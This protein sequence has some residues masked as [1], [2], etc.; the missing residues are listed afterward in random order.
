MKLDLSVHC[1]ALYA[2]GQVQPAEVIAD[3]YDRIEARPDKPHLD[4]PGA[5]RGGARTSARSGADPAAINWRAI[6]CTLRDQRQYRS[7]RSPHHRRL[8]RVRLCAATQRDGGRETP[9]RRRHPHRK[10]ESRS[11]RH[12]PGRHPLALRRV[13]QCVRSALYLGRL[14]LRLGRRG[15]SS[16]GQLFSRHGYRGLR[17]RARRF[18]QSGRT[19]TL[20]RP[21]QH[22]RRSAG[23]PHAR[24][25]LHPDGQLPRCAC[26]L[27]SRKGFRRQRSLLACA[28]LRAR[29]RALAAGSFSLRRAL[30]RSTGVLRR[31]AGAR[32][33][34]T[35]DRATSK[36]WAAKK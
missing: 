9:D 25:R 31:H 36:H 7:R 34:S 3:V 20:A 5:S 24:L 11:I 6:R 26:R 19:Q 12:R 13:L 27:A 23:M 30:G 22:V 1:A 4:F 18:Q 21:A 35:S 8:S 17:T 32:P 33:L 2:S 29:R 10:N 28:A 14:Q 16:T 15:R